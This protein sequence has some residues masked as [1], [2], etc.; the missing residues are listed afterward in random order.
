MRG[1]QKRPRISSKVRFNRNTG[2]HTLLEIM[3][4]AGLIVV[5][6][7]VLG[8]SIISINNTLQLLFDNNRALREWRLALTPVLLNSTQRTLYLQWCQRDTTAHAPQEL[9][10]AAPATV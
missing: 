4:A 5:G 9:P 3:I 1:A 7:G 10:C 6:L 2:G 8:G